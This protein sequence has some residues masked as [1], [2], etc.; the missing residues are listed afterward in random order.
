MIDPDRT[1][2]VPASGR[3]RVRH[4]EDAEGYRTRPP[5]APPAAAQPSATASGP[6]PQPPTT[7]SGPH[8]Q[9]PATGS[10]SRPQ[11]APPSSD[12]RPQPSPSGSPAGSAQGQGR[13][14]YREEAMRRHVQARA[15]AR[16]PL[17]ISGPSFL[18]LWIAV[19]AI[20]VAGA[21][22]LTFALGAGR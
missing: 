21:V 9:P 14:V 22:L 12:S 18:L 19:A 20:L 2:A 10:D 16:M 1:Q 7:A 13:L 17:V 5:Y 4:W 6:H 3:H 8:P 11:P 15:A